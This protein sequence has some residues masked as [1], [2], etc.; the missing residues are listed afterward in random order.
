[1]GVLTPNGMFALTM[2][3]LTGIRGSSA[4]R[5]INAIHDHQRR[6][7]RKFVFDGM[8]FTLP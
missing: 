6:R 7:H 8:V 4:R 2:N 5:D 1:M 3:P